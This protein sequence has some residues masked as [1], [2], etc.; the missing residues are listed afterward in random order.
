MRA[1]KADYEYLRS[2]C[3]DEWWWVGLIVTLLDENDEE[4]DEE[5]CWGFASNDI[6]GLCSEARAWAARMIVKARRV[7]NNVRTSIQV[8]NAMSEGARV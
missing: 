2:W 4:I 7:Q 6:D 3:N 1:M 8:R 5:S